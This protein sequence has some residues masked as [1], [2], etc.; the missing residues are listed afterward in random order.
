MKGATADG[1]PAATLVGSLSSNVTSEESVHRTGQERP[2]SGIYRVHHL[3]HRLPHEVTLLSG[4]RFPRCSKCGEAVS[5][6]LLRSATVQT[7]HHSFAI[8]LFELP[9]LDDGH[10]T[11]P[12]ASPLFRRSRSV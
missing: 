1:V 10:P 5:F 3:Q 6:E 8:D 9:T 11:E 12:S 7:H 2:E 4:K